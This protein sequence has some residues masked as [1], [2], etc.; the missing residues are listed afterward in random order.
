MINI[1]VDV[2]FF[3]KCFKAIFISNKDSYKNIA[4]IIAFDSIYDNFNTKT[5]SFLISSNELI[6]KT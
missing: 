3:I 1:F 4:I 2:C 5:S 6:D